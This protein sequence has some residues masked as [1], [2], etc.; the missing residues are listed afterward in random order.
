M[1]AALHEI[2]NRLM[3]QA[4]TSD[5]ILSGKGGRGDGQAKVTA[6]LCP[7]VAGVAMRFVL[8]FKLRG[9][10]CRETLA[11]QFQGGGMIDQLGSTLRKGL[12]STVR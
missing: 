2:A 7:G 4:M 8:D 12:T 3:N 11:Q 1:D 6:F 10:E 9:S 5:G